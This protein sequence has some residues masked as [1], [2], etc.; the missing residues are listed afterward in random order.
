MNIGPLFFIFVCIS[1]NAQTS[2]LFPSTVKI[3]TIINNKI[4]NAQSIS[5]LLQVNEGTSEIAV[6]TEI[7]SI[8]TGADTLDTLLQKLNT[9]AVVFLK[10]NFPIR[11]L[12]FV[13][14][15]N[16]EQRDFN[17]K[18]Q[19]TIN[20]ITKEQNFTCSVFNLK[21]N[22]NITEHTMVYPMNINLFFEFEPEDYGLD[23]LYKPFVNGVK[24]EVAK[25]FIN[26]LTAFGPSLFR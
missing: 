22:D 20:G 15:N 21:E 4:I 1:S 11:N 16:E 18:A 26:K 5:S 9:S 12:S 8:T 14:S 19:L 17:G 23:K 6:K 7:F 3:E 10:G 13:S 24:M 2:G 25:G